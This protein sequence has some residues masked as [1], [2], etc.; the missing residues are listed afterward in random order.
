ME[1]IS[2]ASSKQQVLTR[3]TLACT[4]VVSKQ[5]PVSGSAICLG[6]M[7]VLTFGMRA[8]MMVGGSFARTS[9]LATGVCG[10][11]EIAAAAAT[12]ETV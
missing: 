1:D 6:T 2:T 8:D 7:R 3:R 12:T 10:A 11:V 4:T 9:A 5:L